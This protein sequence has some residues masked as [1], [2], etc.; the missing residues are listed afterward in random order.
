MK[1]Q[2]RDLVYYF[3]YGS[4]INYWRMFDRL[5]V[6]GFGGFGFRSRKSEIPDRGIPYT[7]EGYKLVFNVGMMRG[8]YANVVPGTK[9]DFVEG[10]LYKLSHS[11]LMDLDKYEGCYKRKYF[12]LPSGELACIYIA[13]PEFCHKTGRPD[14]EYLNIILDGCKDSKLWKTYNMLVDYKNENFNLKKSRH[15]KYEDNQS[16]DSNKII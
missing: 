5:T 4:N 12:E 8:Q 1:I 2:L 9:K 11:Q 15:E 7:L 16:F 6:G 13:L 3:S 10:L 14:L